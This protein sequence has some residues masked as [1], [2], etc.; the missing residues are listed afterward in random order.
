M[1][2]QNVEVHESVFLKLF[3]FLIGWGRED[4]IPVGAPHVPSG[5][6]ILLGAHHYTAG[7]LE[8]FKEKKLHPY[9]QKN[10]SPDA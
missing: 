6:S 2:E 5:T 1:R 7:G 9:K 4:E 8:V 10:D 3:L